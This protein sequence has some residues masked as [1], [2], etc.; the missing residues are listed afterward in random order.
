MAEILEMLNDG[1]W[2]LI[3]DVEARMNL[4][5]SQSKEI[6][7]FLKTY[8]F[9]AVDERNRVKLKEAVREFLAQEATS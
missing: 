2:H 7:E 9:V 5:A 4:S 1:R 3:S 6:I 8:E